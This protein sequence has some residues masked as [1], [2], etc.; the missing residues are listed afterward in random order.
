M[1]I[2]ATGRHITNKRGVVWSRDCLKIL[3]FVVMQSV[4][5]VCQRQLSS[6]LWYSCAAVDKISTDRER[7]TE[8]LI[9]SCYYCSAFNLT[10]DCGKGNKHKSVNH[11]VGCVAHSNN[12]SLCDSVVKNRLQ[13]GCH[14]CITHGYL[15]FGGDQPICG[16]CGLPLTV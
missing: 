14:S 3:P 8:P 4:T 5:W 16:P 2:L 9:A 7:C 6:Y 15:L 1:S 12:V 10:W 11:V 13:I